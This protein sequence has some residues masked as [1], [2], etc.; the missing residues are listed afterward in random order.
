V[1]RKVVLVA[2]SAA[3][4]LPAIAAAEQS[5]H[6][7]P[8]ITYTQDARHVGGE[9]VVFHVASGP[10]PGGLYDLRPVLSN[11]AV[12]GVE[13]LS[14]MQRRMLRRA[15]VVGVNG[16]FF[17]WAL[18]NPS[19]IFVEGGVLKT[20]PNPLRS[21]LGIGLDGRLRIATIRYAGTFQIG[22]AAIRNLKQFNRPF[23]GDRGFA[24]YSR[25][26]G[27]RPP[28]ARRTHELILPDLGRTFPNRDRAGIVARIVKGSGH[29]IPSGG[30]ILQARGPS[31]AIL[32]A[33]ATR[34]LTLTFRL[35]LESWW[36]GVEEAIGGGPLLVR[37][38]VAVYRPGDEFF[39]SDL[40]NQRHPRTA[41][42]QTADGRII[43]LVADGRR[44]RSNG[45]TMNQLANAMVHYGAERAMALDG[46]GSSELAF[47]ARVLNHPSD[48]RERGLA[49]SLQLVYIGA[50]ARQPRR[51]VFS[52]NGDG[53]RDRQRLFAKFVRRSDVHLQVVRPDDTV[54]WDY[55]ARRDPGVITKDLGPRRMQEGS[56]RWVVEGTDLNG[57]DSRM[58]RRFRVNNT[59]GF[60]DLSKQTMRVRRGRGGELRI[61][62][63]STH[64]ADVRVTIERGG[65]VVRHLVSRDGLGAGAYA[66]IW[67]GRN[68][69]EK[70]V[71]SGRFTAVVRAENS[72][73]SVDL[74]KGFTVERVT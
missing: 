32:K 19:G 55:Q 30:A 45:L 28:S 68:D 44:S 8:R 66:V 7:M 48:G 47:N 31:R 43:L 26:W 70:V 54:R 67:N 11:S 21:S 51:A 57:R 5:V 1:L 60:L 29:S 16:D 15:N 34:G 36:D 33:E 6:L 39:S 42:G 71:R 49:E 20:T 73:G 41:V 27:A 65:R 24:L 58:T 53:Y 63:R 2:A 4:V 3:L 74:R 38:G 14:G 40:L 10:Q 18:G 13:T 52:P 61:G 62:F 35:G 69:G 72:L 46:G 50:Y 64:V 25:S 12:T 9:R 56:W 22:E 37:G 23:S 59:L 17:G